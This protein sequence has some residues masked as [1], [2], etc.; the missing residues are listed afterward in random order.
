M[1]FASTLHCSAMCGGIS[2][3]ALLTLGATTY[4]ERL[5]HTLFVQLG[6]I[7]S[8]CLLG[9]GAAALGSTFLSSQ[10]TLTYHS[11]QWIA[12]VVLMWSGLAMA[13]MLPRLLLLDSVMVR[14]SSF[15]ERVTRPLCPTRAAP[16]FL[17]LL[18]GLNPCPMVYAAVFTATLTASPFIGILVMVGFGMGTMPGVV[19][20]GLGLTALKNISLRRPVQLCAGV[21]IALFGFAS[22]YIP[23]STLLAFCMTR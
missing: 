6:R 18:W 14:M 5:K 23:A 7:S 1:G 3:S 13:G 20:T 2:C 15:F 8:Y 19:L 9:G 4:A 11:M 21:F 16:F 17:G 22:L 12:A 10:K